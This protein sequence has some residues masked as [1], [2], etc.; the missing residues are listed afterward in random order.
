M[1]NILQNTNKEK[2]L[3]DALKQLEISS[4]NEKRTIKFKQLWTINTDNLV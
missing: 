2:N 3:N 1:N 4:K